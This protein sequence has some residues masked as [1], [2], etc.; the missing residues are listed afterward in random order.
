MKITTVIDIVIGVVLISATISGFI[1]GIV[2]KAAQLIALI[3]SC[4][5]AYLAANILSDTF[6]EF[7]YDKLNTALD[8]NDVIIDAAFGTMSELAGRLSYLL[9]YVSAFLIVYILS[10]FLL[11]SLKILDHL[12]V[13]DKLDHICGAAAGFL[14]DFILICIICSMIFKTV[15][16]GILDSIGLTKNAIESS[17]LLSVF[18]EN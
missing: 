18:A 14:L 11:R 15:P 3:V 12:P 1:Q 13:F 16:Q 5:I 10:C 17:L 7:I 2:M 9:I 8:E 6:S 4:I